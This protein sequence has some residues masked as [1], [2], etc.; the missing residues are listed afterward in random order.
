M[1]IARHR[2]KS[3][4]AAFTLTEMM[5]TGAIVMMLFAGV[6]TGHL[7][8]VRMFQLTKAKLG[9]TDD[10]RTAITRLIDEIRT[11]KLVK[12][13][14]GS[15]NSFTACGVNAAQQ[16]NAIEIYPTT[17]TN[18]Y[19]RYFL[20]GDNTLCRMP[21]G[22]NVTQV[23]AHYITNQTIF[24]SESFNGTVLTNNENNRVIGLTLQFYQIQYPVI[25]IGQGHLYDFYQLRTKITR[26]T[27][28]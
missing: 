14:T 8:G 18:N 10:A 4:E 11:A 7:A 27:L 1:K 2:A 9:G 28:E 21:S 24:T 16:G 22:S 23:L 15:A 5:V 13:G 26:R 19:V 17:A 20:A 25:R 3:P 6:I 12:L